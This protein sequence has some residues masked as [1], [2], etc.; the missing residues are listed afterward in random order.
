MGQKI[1][2]IDDDPEITNILGD[3]LKAAGYQI[4]VC[5]SGLDALN[6]ILSYKPDLLLLDV[7][8]PGVDGFTLAKQITE[9]AATSELPIIVLSGLEPSVAMFKRFRQVAAFM[10]KPFNP[11]EL[12]EIIRKTLAK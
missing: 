1:L 10:P 3:S 9:G 6:A 12:L 7:M 4:E 2:L 11:E 5:D 8:L